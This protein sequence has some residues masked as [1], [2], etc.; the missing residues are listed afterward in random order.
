MMHNPVYCKAYFSRQEFAL[1]GV[2]LLW[3]TTFLIVHVAMRQCG[4]LLFV[5]LRFV[6]AGVLGLILFRRAMGG[7]T[8]KEAG[9]G[10]AIGV[11]ISLGYALQTY[12]LK[13]VNSS[14]SAFLTALYVPLVPVLQWGVM[15][16]APRAMTWAGIGLAFVGLL[17]L[18]GPDA[19]NVGLGRGEIATLV[20]AVAIAAEI[21]LIGHYAAEVDSTRI[22]VLQLL[23][24][25]ILS[26]GIM[27]LAGEPIP[28]FSWIWL[29]AAL[30]LGIASALIQLTMNWAQKSVSPTRA[31]IIYAS[32]P[33]WG[34][35]VGRIAGDRLPPLALL[36]AAFIVAGVITSELKLRRRSP[37]AFRDQSLF[38]S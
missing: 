19:L 24:A 15:R 36:G 4:P 30:G 6:T 11:T 22:T 29:S 27:P 32:E 13:T 20:S 33:V 28:A 31:T 7:L 12:G 18:A 3:G 21:L 38:E 34:G 8:R 10:V 16:R 5:G 1:I 9:A 26:F 17:C 2:T 35:V 14:T 23:A 25:G 37:D